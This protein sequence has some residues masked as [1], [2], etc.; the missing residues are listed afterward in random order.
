MLCLTLQTRQQ[1][2]LPL[3]V[4][5]STMM[6]ATIMVGMVTITAG[7]GTFT[8]ATTATMKVVPPLLQPPEV[9]M[10]QLLLQVMKVKAV[11][12]QSSSVDSV[13]LL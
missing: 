11:S 3:A 10:Q 5:V 6:G 2:Q 9:M 13:L 1:Q 12:L 8:V 7:M 4:A